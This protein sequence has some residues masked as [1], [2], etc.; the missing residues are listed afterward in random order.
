MRLLG[1]FLLLEAVLLGVWD[2]GVV[3]RP[4]EQIARS[5]S[6]RQSIT[7][8]NTSTCNDVSNY[9]TE[10]DIN[11]IQADMYD[12]LN[13]QSL[14]DT[15]LRDEAKD[16]SALEEALS[17]LLGGVGAVAGVATD[18][19]LLDIYK[20]M[21]FTDYVSGFAAPYGVGQTFSWLVWSLR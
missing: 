4:Y 19:S 17:S 15:Y 5:F 21:Q 2:N 20:T 11:R 10:N 16:T 8:S 3:A 6:K 7:L 14:L 12:M 9:Q 13:A 1:T 18:D